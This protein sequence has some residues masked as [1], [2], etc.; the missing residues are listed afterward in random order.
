MD[1]VALIDVLTAKNVIEILREKFIS[2][3]PCGFLIYAFII[4]W[5]VRNRNAISI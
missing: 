5:N 1:I 3:P 4:K 2:Y